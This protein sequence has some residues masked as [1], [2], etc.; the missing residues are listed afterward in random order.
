LILSP[1]LAG[2]GMA[3]SSISVVGSSLLLNKVK[4]VV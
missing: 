3:L 4:L 2:L 1:E